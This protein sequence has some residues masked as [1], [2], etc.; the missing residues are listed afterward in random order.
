MYNSSV[1]IKGDIKMTEKKY[2]ENIKK[3]YSEKDNTKLDEL[4]SLDKKVKTVPMVFAYVFGSV[5]A[6]I[7]GVG[8]CLAMKVIGGTTTWMVVGILIGI[9][10]LALMTINAPIYFKL[11]NARKK[12]YSAEILKLSNEILNEG[13]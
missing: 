12:K 2:V 4:K 8:M 13:K 5:A 11:L 9:V 10:G 6:L 3:E 7:L 1:K